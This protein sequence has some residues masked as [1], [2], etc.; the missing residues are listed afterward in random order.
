MS[1]QTSSPNKF[2]HEIE[3]CFV[4]HYNPQFLNDWFSRSFLKYSVDAIFPSIRGEPV[5]KRKT[6]HDGVYFGKDGGVIG[7]L[8]R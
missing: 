2:Q 5:K 8:D 4:Q 6:E 1:D 3:V 7:M